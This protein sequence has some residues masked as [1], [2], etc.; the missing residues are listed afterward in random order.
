MHK[1]ISYSRFSL[2]VSMNC[3]S[4]ARAI[5]RHF[6]HQHLL[7]DSY[8]THLFTSAETRANAGQLNPLLY[9]CCPCPARAASHF[10]CLAQVAI[11]V[12]TELRLVTV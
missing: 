2:E 12:Q 10:F 7:L 5:S 3:F 9:S 4:T 11:T 6:L 1:S 8:R